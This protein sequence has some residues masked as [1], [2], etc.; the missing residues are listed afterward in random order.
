[1]WS[2]FAHSCPHLCPCMSSCH[3]LFCFL[4]PPS[5][6][7]LPSLSC[8]FLLTPCSHS[9]HFVLILVFPFSPFLS[10]PISLFLPRFFLSLSTSLGLW[11]TSL[12]VSG[13][14]LGSISTL[15]SISANWGALAEMPQLRSFSLVAW[16]YRYQETDTALICILTKSSIFVTMETC[17]RT[18]VRIFF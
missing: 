3:T 12:G 8:I 4:A 1:M 18:L 14:C 13:F 2:V 6:S 5:C 10:L 7:L 16:A 11:L 17:S 9:C 15:C